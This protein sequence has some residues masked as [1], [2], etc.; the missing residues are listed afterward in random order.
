[1]TWLPDDVPPGSYRYGFSVSDPGSGAEYA[2]VRA[3]D[4]LVLGR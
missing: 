3:A 2:A 4:E 1:M